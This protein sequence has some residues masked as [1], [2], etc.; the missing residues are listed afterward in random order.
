[1]EGL[2]QGYGTLGQKNLQIS[3]H[4]IKVHNRLVQISDTWLHAR[5]QQMDAQRGI[6]PA[7]F[8]DA[9]NFIE[10]EHNAL[11]LKQSQ[12]HGTGA[13]GFGGNYI[14]MAQLQDEHGTV[15]I[16]LKQSTVSLIMNR[17]REF[18][19]HLKIC[20]IHGYTPYIT[21]KKFII[22]GNIPQGYVGYL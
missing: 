2:V 5:W 8:K 15:G 10:E 20:I 17:Q 7:L 22:S 6:S 12:L 18:F 13:E 21:E 3:I 9:V 16:N 4:Q 19:P 11:I 14:C 1:M